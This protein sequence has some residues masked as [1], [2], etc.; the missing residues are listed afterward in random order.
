[1]SP[2]RFFAL[3]Y[4]LALPAAG[5]TGPFP[6]APSVP[7]SDAIPA[8]SPVTVMLVADDAVCGNARHTFVPDSTY[9]TR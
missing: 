8:A 4:S 1:M 6:S 3:L 5:S 2:S 9:S 7:G